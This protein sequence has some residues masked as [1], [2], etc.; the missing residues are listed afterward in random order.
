MEAKLV[1]KPKAKR[2]RIR[3]RASEIERKE[4]DFP[5][6]NT[7]Q[8]RPTRMTMII[9]LIIMMMM[10]HNNRANV[11]KIVTTTFWPSKCCGCVFD[12]QFKLSVDSTHGLSLVDI[13]SYMKK[14]KIAYAKLVT[15]NL[16]SKSENFPF[17]PNE[18]GQKQSQHKIYICWYIFDARKTT[19]T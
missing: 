16:L 12:V 14:G 18:N 5:N 19:P 9:V 17:K 2:K 8:R 7:T 15:R 3:W 11:K 1:M 13:C 10:R 4:E 6:A